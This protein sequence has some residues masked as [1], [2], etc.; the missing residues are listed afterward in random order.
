MLCKSRLAVKC[1]G[2]IPFLSWDYRGRGTHRSPACQAAGWAL[3][4]FL[5]N[6][7]IYAKE[8]QRLKAREREGPRGSTMFRAHSLEG[9]YILLQGMLSFISSICLW[10]HSLHL[11][12]RRDNSFRKRSYLLSISPFFFFSSFFSC[13]K[14]VSVLWAMCASQLGNP[15]L[16][17]TCFMAHSCSIIS[18]LL[19]LYNVSLVEPL[20][21]HLKWLPP[22]EYWIY[23]II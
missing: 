3:F 1:S 13:F 12:Y 19:W 15:G 8:I 22:W 21:Q 4:H 11:K 6:I 16:D 10:S 23:I 2:C 7:S 9:A 14:T 18:L 20:P 5:L 17:Q